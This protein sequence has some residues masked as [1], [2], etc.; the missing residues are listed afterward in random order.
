MPSLKLNKVPF[1]ITFL[2]N[3]QQVVAASLPVTSLAIMDHLTG[4][5]HPNGLYSN[6]VFGKPGTPERDEKFGYINLKT[7][8]FHPLYF[9]TMSK[10]KKLY[11]EICMGKAF[12][13]WDPET[14]D[15]VR[16]KNGLLDGET[17]FEFFLKH[18]NELVFQPG[19]SRE[20]QLRMKLLEQYRKECFISFLVV[21]PASIRDIRIVEGGRPE[22]EEINDLYKKVISASNSI[23]PA[24]EGME[25]GILDGPKRALQKSVNDVYEYIYAMVEG[26][27]GFLSG[28]FGARRVFGTT[29]NV[30]SSMEVDSGRMGDARQPSLNTTIVG[31]YQFM[32]ATEIILVNH[33]LKN[34]IIKDFMAEANGNPELINMKTLKKERVIMSNKNKDKWGTKAGI[35]SLI[36]GFKY[37]QRR[38]NPIILDGY[39]LKLIYQDD[40][41]FMVLNDIGELPQGLDKKYVRPMTWAEMFYLHC[42]DI[43]PRVRNFNTRYPVT[44]LGSI[45]PSKPYL[46]TTTSGLMLKRMNPDGTVSNESVLE[47]PRTTDN[48]AFH[49]TQCVFPAMLGH[50]GADRPPSLSACTVMCSKKVCELLGSVKAL[51]PKRNPKG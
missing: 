38:H 6:L 18:W 46:K 24:L 32:K 35:E 20:R 2:P 22:E 30:I 50:L 33:S 8:I 43:V 17:G 48:L 5:Y 37:P 28:K 49:D 41:K 47:F 45:Y 36:N 44:G 4:D 12:A 31:L 1:N 11:G 26:K 3:S 19:K 51:L 15:F 27:S 9:H 39:Y 7:K 16:A 10:L 25:G 14:K 13:T 21:I 23:N 40:E 42:T 29:R 34:G